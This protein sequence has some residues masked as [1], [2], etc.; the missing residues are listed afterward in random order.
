MNWTVNILGEKLQT[1]VD[2]LTKRKIPH[3]LSN[4]LFCPFVLNFILKILLHSHHLSPLHNFSMVRFPPPPPKTKTN[5]VL[6][7]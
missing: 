2:G 7:D 5:I 3:K 6:S 1:H 4:A